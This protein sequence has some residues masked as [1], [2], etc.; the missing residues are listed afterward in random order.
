MHYCLMGLA[1]L[2]ISFNSF[3]AESKAGVR[4]TTAIKW[5]V[6]GNTRFQKGYVRKD[7]QGKV[8]VQ[9]LASSQSPHAVVLSCSDSR[10][11]PE[12]V[13]DQKLGEIFTVRTAGQALDNNAVGS[14]E[15][16][17]EHLGSRLIVVMGHTSCGAVK[18]AHSTLSGS[19]AGTPALDGLVADIHPRLQAYKGKAPSAG[20]SEEAWANAEGVARDLLRR[21]A[22]LSAKWDKGEIWIVPSLYDLSTG[23][24]AFHEN[25]SQE[26]KRTPTSAKN[27]GDASEPN[28]ARQ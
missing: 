7:G 2:A 21:S 27:S 8:D 15:Y 9:R 10:V 22:L 25:L 6:N 5:L 16:A 1:A 12:L 4:P 13:F 24:V 23:K 20:Y 3:A 14:V 26:S 18:A 28:S 17:V 11:P 19:S